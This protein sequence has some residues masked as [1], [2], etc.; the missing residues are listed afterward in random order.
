MFLGVKTTGKIEIAIN[1]NANKE[2]I[3]RERDT[4]RLRRIRLDGPIHLDTERQHVVN[5][6]VYIKSD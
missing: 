5:W 1:K 6:L 4:N 2:K 3:G